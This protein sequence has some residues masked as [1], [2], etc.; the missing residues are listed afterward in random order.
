MIFNEF[1]FLLLFL[2]ALVFTNFVL[3]AANRR[4]ELLLAGSLFFYCLSGI[5]HGLVLMVGLIWVF[6]VCRS[7]KIIGNYWRVLLAVIGPAAGLIYYKYTGFAMDTVRWL[8]GDTVADQSFSLFDDVL[9]PAGIS[10]F[11]FQLISFAIDRFRG[12]IATAPAF[13]SFALYISFFPQLVAGPILRFDQ[14]SESIANLAVFRPTRDEVVDAIGYMVFGL[15]VKVV[16]GDSLSSAMAPAVAAPGALEPI[17][18]L[19]VVLGYSFQIYFD[20]YG[21]SLIAIGL[22]R[23]FGFHFPDN[24]LRPY[25]AL[26]PRDF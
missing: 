1:G 12:E 8:T 21:Y 11:S 19:Y 13:R 5:E 15:L 17:G 26:N 14:V 23:L 22:G 20:F 3:I 18:A 25:E 6:L 16:L 10:F 4:R 24:F 7:N 9:L 2:P